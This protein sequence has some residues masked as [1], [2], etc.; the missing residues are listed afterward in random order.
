MTWSR[1][2][3]LTSQKCWGLSPSLKPLDS[4]ETQSLASSRTGGSVLGRSGD[5]FNH[6]TGVGGFPMPSSSLVFYIQNF[7]SKFQTQLM[8]ITCYKS[9]PGLW[10]SAVSCISSSGTAPVVAAQN[11]CLQGAVATQVHF[12]NV[13]ATGEGCQ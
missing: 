7:K 2:F 12:S 8:N 10:L 11:F 6:L 3:K 5:W 1:Q 13:K 4:R 9:S